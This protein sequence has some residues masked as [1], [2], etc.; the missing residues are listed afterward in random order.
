M[1]G[2]TKH[3]YVAFGFIYLF[4]LICAY[5]LSSL[6]CF[7]VFILSGIVFLLCRNKSTNIKLYCTFI[8]VAFLVSG[9][10]KTLIAEKNEKLIDKEGIVK[11]IVTDVKTP[12]NDT[13]MIEISGSCND[14]PVK[15]AVFTID[16]GFS[17]G[18]SIEIPVSFSELKNSA[19][20]NEQLY[21]YSKGIFLRGYDTGNITIT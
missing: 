7:M 18:N 10:H 21:Y 15:I 3:K 5:F 2:T 16:S 11:G 13:V 1:S 9:F 20:F 12:D 19:E 8:G 6:L 17:P 4:A 14:I